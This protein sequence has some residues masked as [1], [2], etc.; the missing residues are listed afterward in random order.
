VI[1]RLTLA[2]TGGYGV[3][4]LGTLLGKVLMLK[5]FNVVVT[6]D[7]DAASRGGDIISYLVYSDSKIG[8]PTI[9]E[10][11]ILLRFTKTNK[12]FKCVKRIIDTQIANEF[13]GISFPF[14]KD[15]VEKFKDSRVTN[16]I[17]LG[18]LLKELEINVSEEELKQIIPPRFFVKNLEAI[19]Y[20]F[21]KS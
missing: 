4:F 2:G 15:A 1:R 10:A 12:H 18:K 3:K 5:G 9:D 11:D 16:M 17:A 20:G 14:S 21:D 6:F 7:Y 13:E 8:N 19:R